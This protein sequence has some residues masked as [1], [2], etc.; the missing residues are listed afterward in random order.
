MAKEDLIGSLKYL[1]EKL[2]IRSLIDL[3]AHY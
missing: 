1:E 2:A 3:R